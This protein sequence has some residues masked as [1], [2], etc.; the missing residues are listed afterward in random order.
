MWLREASSAA[1]AGEQA[2]LP[3]P[4]SSSTPAPASSRAAPCVGAP[5]EGRMVVPSQQ[6]AVL[7]LASLVSLG[8]IFAMCLRCRKRSKIVQE[9]NY[10][11]DP[12]HLSSEGRT[13]K[14][15]RSKRVTNL[16]QFSSSSGPQKNPSANCV[17]VAADQSS[18]QNISFH[19]GSPTYVDPIA[20]LLYQNLPEPSEDTADYENVFPTVDTHITQDSGK[21]LINRKVT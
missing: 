19:N 18:Y 9:E 17:A 20:S 15:T 2:S 11:Y 1:P 14:V 6:G 5:A 21:P 3:A 7:V 4:S 12:Q 16:N 13:I 10:L 8:V